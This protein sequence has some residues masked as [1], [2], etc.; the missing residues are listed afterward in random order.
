MR[1]LLVNFLNQA[2]YHGRFKAYVILTLPLSI[3][4]RVIVFVRMQAY[5]SGL[6]Q[7]HRLPVPVIVVGNLTVGGTGKT[8]LVMWLAGFLAEHGYIPC[9]ISRGYG[10][11]ATRMPQQVRP[12]SDPRTVGD[13]PIMISNRCRCQVAVSADRAGAGKALLEHTDCNII[14][15]DDG[16]QHYSLERDIEIAVVDGVRRYGNQFMLPSGPLREPL[17]RLESVDMIV[18]NGLADRYEFSM[19]FR[20]VD[21][22]NIIDS[23]I[24]RDVG[25]F[26]GKTVHAVA[27]IGNNDR[28]FQSL[29][30]LGMKVIEHPYPDHYILRDSEIHFDDDYD[31]IMTEKDAVRIKNIAGPRHWYLEIDVEMHEH[32]GHRLL[33]KIEEVIGNG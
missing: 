16:L 33:R 6:L 32:F 7:T 25:S 23:S 11:R 31:V 4:F 9:I 18:A 12:D 30:K 22:R 19:S 29:K 24:V 26:G 3:L 27:A 17:K 10:G 5:R 14:I 8:P 2:W 28:F 13:E 21:I 1:K 20:E 15:C